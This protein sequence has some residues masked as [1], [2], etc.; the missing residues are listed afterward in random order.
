MHNSQGS[1]GNV[2]T[3]G[4]GPAQDSPGSNQ[5]ST[6]D[7]PFANISYELHHAASILRFVKTKF[8]MKLESG[9]SQDQSKPS[10]QFRPTAMSHKE[11]SSYP[12]GKLMWTAAD[13]VC[14]LRALNFGFEL[15]L[16]LPDQQISW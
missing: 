12:H 6:S 7:F 16:A 14:H 4:G 5:T 8:D 2:D 11:T 10:R 9:T 15:V 1:L 3:C 13:T